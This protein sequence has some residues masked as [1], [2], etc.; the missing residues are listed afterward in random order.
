MLIQLGL[1]PANLTYDVV[2]DRLVD[3]VLAN[4]NVANSMALIGAGSTSSR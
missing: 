3:V 2:F 1:D 4:I